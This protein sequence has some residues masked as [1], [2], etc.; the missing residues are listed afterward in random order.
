MPYKLEAI[1]LVDIRSEH[2]RAIGAVNILVPIRA[3]D[4]PRVT[5]IKGDNTDWIGIY[6]SVE[7]HLSPVNA[8]S[9]HTTALVIGAGG[10]APATIYA[11]AQLG[12][13]HIFLYNRT[14]SRA[15]ILAERFHDQPLPGG[16]ARLQIHVIQSLDVPAILSTGRLAMPTIIISA[17][18]AY[19]S[20]DLGWFGSKT[21]GVVLELNYINRAESKLLR[22]VESRLR[23]KGWIPLDGLKSLP[24]QAYRQ[25]EMW[26]GKPAPRKAMLESVLRQ[27]AG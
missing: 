6:C 5:A 26:T 9:A 8:V 19:L 10:V 1:D 2:A 23:L 4:S 3:G 11:L 12:V 7:A 14:H 16:N 20:L 13:Q 21:G 15:Q 17:A 24:E 22:V 18:A 27:Y 25:F